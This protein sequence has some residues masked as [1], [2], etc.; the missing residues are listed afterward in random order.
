[1]DTSLKTESAILNTEKCDIILSNSKNEQMNHSTI[2]HESQDIP[3]SNKDSQEN[4][5]EMD[6]Q[7]VINSSISQSTSNSLDNDNE[8]NTPFQIELAIQ[9]TQN[10]D[11]N[12]LPSKNDQSNH[13]II[14]HQ[15][16]ND[17][18]ASINQSIN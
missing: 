13:S 4:D 2:I 17:K 14:K 15:S 5:V 11:I 6:S 16:Q 7:S 12:L 1:M 18:N 10:P 9:N 3:N 8:T